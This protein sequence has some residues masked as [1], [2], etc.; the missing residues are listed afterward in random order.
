MHVHTLKGIA[1]HTLGPWTQYQP[2]LCVPGTEADPCDIDDDIISHLN[3]R[4]PWTPGS[5]L[6]CREV[7]LA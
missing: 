1:Q 7:A 5:A 2:V 6:G 4:R 3:V